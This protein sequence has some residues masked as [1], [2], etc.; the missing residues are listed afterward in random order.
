MAPSV[1]S[2]MAA[3]DKDKEPDPLDADDVMRS[4]VEKLA[5]KRMRS[6]DLFRLIDTSRDGSISADELK[7]GLADLGFKTT[8]ESFAL[9]MG[10]IDKDRGGEI[11][12]KEF[13]RAI[14]AAEKLPP[15]KKKE[16]E[17][18]S[19]KKKPRKQGLTP[20]D[21]EEFRQIFSLFK[22][23]CRTKVDDDG[24]EVSLVDMD[25]SGGISVD[26]LEQL[27]ETIG[28]HI[29]PKELEEMLKDIDRDNNGEI[30]FQEFC[31]NMS[32][33][34]QVPYATDTIEAAFLAFARNAPEGMIRVEDL[35]NSLQI[36]LHKELSPADVDDL[37]RYYE[38]CFVTVPGKPGKYFCYQEYIDIMS[39]MS[40]PAA[41]AAAA[42]AA[43]DDA[44]A[45]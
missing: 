19:T 2:A 6:A 20:E 4:L 45:A 33:Q 35:R 21:V 22:Q 13:E 27:L 17:E 30:D 8:P 15:K 23:L 5:E 26:E 24:N 39:P 29:S 25:D 32:K 7:T 36:Y 43:G 42:L 10:R 11:E 12:M 31:D 16:E 28:M 44:A 1:A 37:I 3:K 18:T 14:K 9:I 34:I 41:A 40:D 38:D